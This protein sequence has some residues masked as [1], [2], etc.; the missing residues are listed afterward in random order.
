[1][2]EL[3]RQPP[4]NEKRCFQIVTYLYNVTL[5]D[6]DQ[7][8]A[9]MSLGAAAGV[10][11]AM[12]NHRNSVRV[13]TRACALLGVLADRNEEYQELIYNAGGVPNLVACMMSYMRGHKLLQQEATKALYI[14][15]ELPKNADQFAMSQGIKII[16]SVMQ[17]Y[18]SDQAIQENA[19][20]ILYHVAQVQVEGVANPEL[21]EVI[22]TTLGRHKK[23]KR[24]HANGCS[25]FRVLAQ[26]GSQKTRNSMVWA[27]VVPHVLKCMKNNLSSDVVQIEACNTISA[28]AEDRRE[29]RVAVA[30]EGLGIIFDAM[31]KHETNLKVQLA[32]CQLLLFVAEGPTSSFLAKA[33][34]KYSG[35]KIL[36]C[37][38]RTFDEPCGKMVNQILKCYL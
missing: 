33:M 23:A 20:G 11:I 15:T 29:V 8:V 32:A 27:D 4:I 35:K 30:E 28:L 1:M 3:A 22:V 34:K 21:I 24:V 17:N 16:K 37:T 7:R 36:E 10:S 6:K 13:Q 31:K 26:R 12:S 38:K 25:V 5:K 2:K 19:C 9:A 14:L 18:A